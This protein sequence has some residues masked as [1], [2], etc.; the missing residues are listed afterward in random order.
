M[1]DSPAQT[2]CGSEPSPSLHSK[3][4]KVPIENWH[5]SIGNFQSRLRFLKSMKP[6]SLVAV[7]LLASF[8][9][10]CS[11]SKDASPPQAAESKPPAEEEAGPKVSR[12]AQGQVVITMSDEA[13]GQMGIAV[14]KTEPSQMSPE[15]KGYG[16]VLDPAPLVALVNELE[17]ARAAYLASSNEFVRLKTL[18]GQGNA[19]ARALQTAEANAMHDQ[20][21][22]QSA[23]DRLALSWGAAIAGQPNLADAVQSLTSQQTALLRIELP[24]G[25]ALSSPPSSARIS[26]LSAHSGDAQLLGPAPNVDPSMQGQGFIYL[27]KPNTSRLAPGEAVTG[28]LQLPG[29]P[30]S[31]VIIPRDSVVRAEGAAWVYHFESGAGEAFTRT[32]ITL[33]H[34]TDT[35]WFVTNRI[36]ANE[37]IVTTGAQ[38]LMSLEMKGKGGEE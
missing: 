38:Q 5:F 11:P 29:E 24:M 35:G 17:S 26:T 18:Q 9:F 3:E 4:A 14:K 32:E 36:S 2:G 7:A 19:S 10:G 1:R 25:Q 15:L 13:Q 31:G 30:L 23:K 22:I 37:Y 34:P 16:R 21:A 8:L 12:N 28:Y 27:V 33:D 20:L 6:L